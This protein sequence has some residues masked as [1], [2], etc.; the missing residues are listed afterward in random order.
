[1][2]TPEQAQRWLAKIGGTWA[3]AQDSTPEKARIIVTVERALG[4]TI[5]RHAVFDDRLTGYMRELAIREALANA[6][7]ELR[8]AIA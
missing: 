8:A 7:T 5:T 6:C 4:G 2:V 1:M 3:E